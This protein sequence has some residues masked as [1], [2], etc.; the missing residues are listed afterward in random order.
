MTGSGHGWVQIRKISEHGF[1]VRA[2]G[3]AP[4]DDGGPLSQPP[5]VA[6]LV[7]QAWRLPSASILLRRQLRAEIQVEI[8]SRRGGE[9]IAASVL[10]LVAGRDGTLPATP[11]L[12]QPAPLFDHS[13][14]CASRVG[15]TS[16]PSVLAACKLMTNWNLVGCITGSSAG[17]SPLRIRP[18]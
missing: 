9:P 15:G 18:T 12:R 13:S 17:F 11:A 5:A 3:A 8:S 14:A 10:H 1:R 6:G 2:C 4:N 16:M 7:Q